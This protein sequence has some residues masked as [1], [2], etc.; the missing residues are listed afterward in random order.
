MNIKSRGADAQILERTLIYIPIIHTQADMGA[1]SEAVRRATLQKLGK[2]SWKRKVHLTD[3][4]WTDIEQVIDALDLP[5]GKVR[6]YQD[7]LPV[8]GREVEIVTELAKAG[9][10]NHRLVLRLM[11]RGATIMGTE[12]SELLVEEYERIKQMMAAGGTL[13]ASKSKA[14]QKALGD[15]LLIKRDQFIADRINNTLRAGE[16]G[17]LFLGMLHALEN[18]LDKDIKVIY[19]INRPFSQRF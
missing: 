12:S 7:G 11:E 9:G 8:C 3:K 16:T 2:K 19:Q 10:R 13:E 14:P 4:M 15:L 18:W 17:I 6:L 1:L 5:Y